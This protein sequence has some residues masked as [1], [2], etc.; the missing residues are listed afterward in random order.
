ML[1]PNEFVVDIVQK[2]EKPAAGELQ[3]RVWMHCTWS[4]ETIID[5]PTKH[6]RLGAIKNLFIYHQ[7]NIF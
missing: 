3:I 4:Y 1:K 5:C 2:I 6:Q 7:K